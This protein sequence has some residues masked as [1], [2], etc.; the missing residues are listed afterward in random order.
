MF[1]N[2]QYDGICNIGFRPTFE[3]NSNG[4]T[5]EV[6]LTDITKTLN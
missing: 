1:D 4:I 5:I 3:N 6:H 2:I